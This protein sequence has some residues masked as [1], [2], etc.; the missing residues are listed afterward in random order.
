M[1]K[2]VI[3]RN[4]ER[5]IYCTPQGE[6]EPI[7]PMT[8]WKWNKLYQIAGKYNIGPWVADGFR[9]YEGD[10]FLNV[11]PTL[12]QKILTQSTSKDAECLDRFQLDMDRKVSVLRRLSRHSL[13]V[14]TKD[15][16]NAIK[17]IEE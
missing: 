11:S 8:E 6:K 5:L 13:R 12:K 3:L 14:Y 4:L 17:S 7:E 2:D 16:I 10:F 9:C 1:K 15:F